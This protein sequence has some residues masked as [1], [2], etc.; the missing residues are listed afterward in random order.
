MVKKKKIIKA[1][2]SFEKRIEEHKKKIAEY[3][4]EESYLRKYWE[5]EIDN[6]GQ[7]IKKREKKL[8][9]KGKNS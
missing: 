5:G 2:K 8:G 6:Y 4:G 9:K 1:I 3:A 7:Q